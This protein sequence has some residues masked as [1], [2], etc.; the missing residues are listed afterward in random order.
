MCL[1]RLG[2]TQPTTRTEKENPMSERF[3]RAQQLAMFVHSGQI[4]KQTH[5]AH[6]IPLPY[7]THPVAVAT[8]VQRYDGPRTR[9]SA[10]CCTTCSKTGATN[11][12]DQYAASSAI[13]FCIS[14]S[15]APTARPISPA[16]RRRGRPASRSTSITSD[17]PMNLAYPVDCQSNVPMLDFRHGPSWFSND[18]SRVSAGIPR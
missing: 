3:N 9:S 4:R 7:I 14:S 10:G 16:R 15:S 18:A 1:N 6:D 13:V 5:N 17:R 12:L 8:L 2:Q 11:G